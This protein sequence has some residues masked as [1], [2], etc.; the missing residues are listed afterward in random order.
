MKI[1]TDLSF[2]SFVRQFVSLSIKSMPN[3]NGIHFAKRFIFID[4]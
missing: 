1:N 2:Y 4:R 3:G